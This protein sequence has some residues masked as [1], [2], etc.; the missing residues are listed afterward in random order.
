[1]RSSL[2]PRATITLG[3]N[4]RLD[5]AE[6]VEQ[7]DGAGWAKVIAAGSTVAVSVSSAHGRGAMLVEVAW[8]G[9]AIDR[10]RYFPA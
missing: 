6:L 7:L 3:D 2:S 8:P 4:D 10:I 9:N 5:V 1:V